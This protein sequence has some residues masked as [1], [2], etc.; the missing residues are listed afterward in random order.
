ML[1]NQKTWQR[2]DR[3]PRLERRVDFDDYASTRDF[4]DALAQI[5]KDTGVYPDISFGRTYVNITLHA[6]PPATDMDP[7]QAVL[8]ERVDALCASGSIGY[9]GIEASGHEDSGHESRH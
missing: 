9:P 4:L 8:A 5:S 6:D 3:P 7:K 1:T 2:R